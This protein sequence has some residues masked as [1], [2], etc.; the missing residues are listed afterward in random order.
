MTPVGGIPALPGNGFT[1]TDQRML[2]FPFANLSDP[3]IIE[4]AIR[5]AEA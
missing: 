2:R 5:L 3:E 1:P 4:F